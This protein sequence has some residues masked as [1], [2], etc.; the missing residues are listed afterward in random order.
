MYGF[1]IVLLELITRNK[2]K[3][4]N[5]N[6]IDT[7]S[8]AFAKG[9]VSLKEIFD[10][11]IVSESNLNALEEIGK[12][13]TD[14][15]TLDTHRR[16][17]MQD[18]EK[19]LIIIWKSLRGQ[20]LGWLKKLGLGMIS[21]VINSQIYNNVRIFT[22]R[23]LIEIT[24]NY[25]YI[26]HHGQHATVYKGSLEDNTLVA[27]KKYH[28]STTNEWPKYT[29]AV[30]VANEAKIISHI[31][32]K[33]IIRLLSLWVG[34][35]IPIL[36]YEYASKGTLADILYCCYP[37]EGNPSDAVYSGRPFPLA[38]RLKI[39]AKT[40]EALAY[41]HSSATGV[42]VHGCLTPYSILLD[43]KFMPMVSGFSMSRNLTLTNGSDIESTL[44]KEVKIQQYSDPQWTRFP[45]VD[46]DLYSF[47]VLLMDLIIRK[48]IILHDIN[49]VS[50]FKGHY[51]RGNTPW[52]LFDVE[53]TTEDDIAIL[54][55]IGRLAV[56][57][58]DEEHAARPTMEEVAQLLKRYRKKRG[59]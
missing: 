19:Q 18:V 24:Q 44:P 45:T 13:A 43:D 57:C 50:E 9:R 30:S 28:N 23:E 54:D 35:N 39:A 47:G 10:A 4:D 48:P 29:A 11:Q 7:F 37:T 40:A 33:N 3:E 32:H 2:V 46:G 21:L 58:T 36:V 27:V 59:Q 15:L 16:P 34:F 38:L 25:S 8:K 31:P 55:E 26:L 52:A 6:L 5:I 49:F 22:K 17:K 12:L 14:C 20:E 51:M 1:G 56:Q 41:M 53:I 42:V